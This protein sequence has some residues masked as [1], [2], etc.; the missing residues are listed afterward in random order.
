MAFY[1]DELFRFTFQFVQI[2]HFPFARD[3][4]YLQQNGLQQGFSIPSKMQ[5]ETLVVVMVNVISYIL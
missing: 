2:K 3:Q 1:Q 4:M 5:N